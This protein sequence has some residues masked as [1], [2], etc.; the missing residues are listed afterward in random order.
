VWLL[1]SSVYATRR[2]RALRRNRGFAAL[3]TPKAAADAHGG[4]DDFDERANPQDD[5]AARQH[6]EQ[7]EEANV[8]YGSNMMSGHARLQRSP[9]RKW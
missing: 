1:A 4:D 8:P 2:G 9:Q 5:G 3:A 6:E 7:K